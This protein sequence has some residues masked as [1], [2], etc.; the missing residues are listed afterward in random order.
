MID[1]KAVIIRPYSLL[2]KGLKNKKKI[3][4][5]NLETQVSTQGL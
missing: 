3:Q 1:L 5:C 2:E 4:V